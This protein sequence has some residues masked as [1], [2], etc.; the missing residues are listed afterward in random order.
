MS[1]KQMAW[2]QT[3]DV[4]LKICKTPN[5]SYDVLNMLTYRSMIQLAA[6]L[7]IP[8]TCRHCRETAPSLD[9]LVFCRECK[10]TFHER[11]WPNYEDHIESDFTLKPCEKFTNLKVHIWIAHLHT[12]QLE[13]KGLLRELLKDRSHRW[14]GIPET[15]EYSDYHPDLLL[16]GALTKQFT[17]APQILERLRPRKQHP[18]VIS[19]IGDTGMGKSTIVKNL[20][21]HL[22]SSRLFE[23]PVTGSGSE[24]QS[25]TS[26][27]VH[28][29]TDPR[30]FSSERPII[31]A[32]IW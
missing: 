32:G 29:Y 4:Y 1:S 30:S 5:L 15:S 27:G 31:Y 23:T 2:Q 20:I 6:Q 12:S 14:I 21:R 11:C 18:R 24:S 13:K 7:R 9:D 22:S 25:S 28:I 8:L 3:Q 19:L 26:G 16:Y 10:R 17:R